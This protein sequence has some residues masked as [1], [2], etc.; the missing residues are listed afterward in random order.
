MKL[1]L[2]TQ[3]NR[4]GAGQ[5][6]CRSGDLHLALAAA[7]RRYRNRRSTDRSG[8]VLGD[9]GRDLGSFWQKEEST[10]LAVK[11]TRF[12]KRSRPCVGR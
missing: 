2:Q 10:D 8:P 5:V 6:T 4:I 12:M 9:F 1:G 11:W 7:P 3:H